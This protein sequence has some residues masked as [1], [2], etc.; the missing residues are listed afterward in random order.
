MASPPPPPS[1]VISMEDGKEEAILPT[2]EDAILPTVDSATLQGRRIYYRRALSA[3]L[4]LMCVGVTWFSQGE[5]LG[6][7]D[8]VY[9][10][11]TTLTNIG[12]GDVLPPLLRYPSISRTITTLL[13]CFGVLLVGNFAAISV[14]KRGRGS[15]EQ[16]REDAIFQIRR[17]TGVVLAL[18]GGGTLGLKIMGGGKLTTQAY[19]VMQTLTTLGLGDVKQT[20]PLTKLFL[21]FYSLF[22]TA[23]FGG[24]VGA[25]ASIPLEMNEKKAKESVLDSLPD[26]L[27]STVYKFLSS[28]S[29]VQRLGL[30]RSD[31]YC[32]RNEFTLLVLVRQGLVTEEELQM[33]RDKFDKLDTD[34]SGK[35]TRVDLVQVQGRNWARGV[36]RGLVRGIWGWG[37][38]RGRSGEERSDEQ[39]GEEEVEVEEEKEKE[40]EEE[41]SVI[42]EDGSVIEEEGSVIEEVGEGEGEG[43]KG[44]V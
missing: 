6:L 15:T 3:L 24:V 4:L 28:G 29:I 19:V 13:S 30:S 41:G 16:G 32:T 20:S 22:G 43:V 18:W 1:D 31:G 12:H 33:C 14:S 42:E 11:C 2:V 10:V 23:I 21:S 8:S 39:D 26:E 9:F 7:V 27:N 25:M 36:V 38:E 44:E 17:L 35:I 5:G 37:G 34:G 40:E